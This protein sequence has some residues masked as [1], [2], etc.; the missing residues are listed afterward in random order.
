VG[1]EHKHLGIDSSPH[2]M[3]SPRK[4]AEEALP[5]D[6]QKIRGLRRAGNFDFQIPGDCPRHAYGGPVAEAIR[7]AMRET[8]EEAANELNAEWPTAAF[9]LRERAKRIEEES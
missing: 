7:R 8:L 2:A 4:L 9:E 6:C 5:C 1:A 3:I